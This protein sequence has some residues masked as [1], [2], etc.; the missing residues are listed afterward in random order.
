[1]YAMFEEVPHNE[2][3]YAEAISIMTYMRFDEVEQ[4]KDSFHTT[5]HENMRNEAYQQF[6]KEKAEKLLDVVALKFPNIRDC[7]QN[8]YTSTPLSYRDYMGTT[9]GSMYGIVKDFKD[10][11]KTMV[12]VKTKVPNLLLTGQSINLHGVLGVTEC[13]LLTCMNILGKEYLLNKIHEAN[14]QTA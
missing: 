5:L 9:D 1:M 13:A 7:I 11:M 14:A 4:W 6:K 10:P 3:G 2:S 12:S 8:Y